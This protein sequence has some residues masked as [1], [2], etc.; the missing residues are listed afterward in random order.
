MTQSE[1]ITIALAF[2][3]W[4]CTLISLSWVLGR[5]YGDLK[6]EIERNR[7][8]INEA[9]NSL[10]RLVRTHDFLLQSQISHIQSH[11]TKVTDY[12]PPTLNNF[13]E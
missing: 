11:L 4:G 13:E 9:A 3:G 7:R 6:A 1:I 10:R 8:D 12:S 5:K 2:V